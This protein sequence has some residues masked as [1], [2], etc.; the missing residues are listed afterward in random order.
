MSDV[1]NY[2]PLVS[3]AM[4]THNHAQFITK[5]VESVLAQRT[6]FPLELIIGDDASSDGTR[7]QIELVSMLA[8][9]VVRTLFHPINIG[10]H[11]NME[12]VLEKCRGQFVAFLEGD[13]YWTCGNKLQLQVDALR[14]RSDAIGAFHPVTVVDA[15]GQET[16][17][18]YPGICRREIWTEDMLANNDI[19]TAS[20]M[21]RRDA[22]PELPESFRKL[23][24]RDWPMWIF[25][26]L[27][28]PWFSIPKLMAAYRRHGHGVWSRLSHFEAECAMANALLEMAVE[29]PPPF[30]AIAVEQAV[31]RHLR[32]L[33]LASDRRADVRLELREVAR[34]IPYYRMRHGKRLISGLWQTLSPRTHRMAKRVVRLARQ[35]AAKYCHVNDD[36]QKERMRQPR[37]RGNERPRKGGGVHPV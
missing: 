15:L 7:E 36:M 12:S 27:R 14:A 28:G 26:S 4:I 9:Q 35:R 19:P 31:E 5:A 13:D 22:L 17:Q 32:R 6:N 10:M 11:R 2:P 1:S 24:M 8:P 20:V 25:A 21:I 18:I 37:D 3:V 23:P 29:L 30:S 16:G 34:L 33:A